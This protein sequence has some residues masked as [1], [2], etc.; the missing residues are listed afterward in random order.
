MLPTDD[1]PFYLA[2][3]ELECSRKNFLCDETPSPV[4]AITLNPISLSI[5]SHRMLNQ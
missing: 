5:A 4:S 1:F 3:L 2:E